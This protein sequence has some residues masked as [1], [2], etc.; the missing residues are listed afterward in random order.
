VSTYLAPYVPPD[1]D[2]AYEEWGCNCGPAA[3]AALLG[4]TCAEVRP[5]FPRF[6]VK[7]YANPSDL[8]YALRELRVPFTVTKEWPR[9][10]LVFVQWGG[11]WLKPGVP[12]GAAYARTHW[13]AVDGDGVFDVNHPEWIAK[14]HWTEPEHGLAAWI[15][16]HVKG[17][18]GTWTIR[19]ALEAADA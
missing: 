19:T 12:I 13:I 5:Y 16:Q 2:A 7:R 17:C 14:A 3:V 6:D 11:A 18:D 9:R 1:L 8:Q 10:G 15:M 4:K